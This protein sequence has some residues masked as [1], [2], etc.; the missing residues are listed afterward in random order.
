MVSESSGVG[1]SHGSGSGSGSGESSDP[2]CLVLPNAGCTVV[3][4]ES[5]SGSPPGHLSII[6]GD[7]IEGEMVH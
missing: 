2:A 1:T 5:Y 3:C 4:I 6:Q 7:L